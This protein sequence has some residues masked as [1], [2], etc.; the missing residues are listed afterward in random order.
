[1]E[2]EILTSTYNKTQ[3]KEI[4]LLSDILSKNGYNHTLVLRGRRSLM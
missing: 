1:M 2:Q 3:T 4:H